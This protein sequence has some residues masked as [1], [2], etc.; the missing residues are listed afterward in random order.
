MVRVGKRVYDDVEPD[1]TSARSHC[2]KWDFP[3]H[4]ENPVSTLIEDSGSIDKNS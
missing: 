1:R 3:D 2:G 4:K